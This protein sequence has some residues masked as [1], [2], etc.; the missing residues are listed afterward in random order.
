MANTRAKRNRA[1]TEKKNAKK[2]LR[3]ERRVQKQRR[4]WILIGVGILAA[5]LI[6][7]YAFQN[8]PQSVSIPEARLSNDPALGGPNAPVVI[9]EF[10]DFNCPSCRAWH[11]AGVMDQILERYGDQVRFVWRDF[12]VITAQSPKLAE[13]AQCTQDQGSFWEYHDLLFENAPVTSVRA[14][15]D[16]A[17]QLGLDTNQFDE[18]LDSGLHRAT[19]DRDLREAYR[20]GFR[21]TPSFMINDQPLVGPTPERMVQIIDSVLASQP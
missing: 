2:A 4:Q 11:L 17:A 6:G 16:Y 14:M 12:P 10:G 9:T 15:K 18:C 1:A 13:A 19:V 20:Q 5:L 21:G 3:R 7:G 8:R